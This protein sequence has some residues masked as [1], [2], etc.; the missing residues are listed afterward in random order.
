MNNQN[1][2]HTQ[3]NHAKTNGHSGSSSQHNSTHNHMT[4]NHATNHNGICSNDYEGVEQ[5]ANAE[6][7]FF[8]F[9]I[10]H[11]ELYRV[12]DTPEANFTN[13]A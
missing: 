11:G 7:C 4:N 9:E 6:M 5:V 13:E 8:C 3:T 1:C 10:L 12:D 2:N